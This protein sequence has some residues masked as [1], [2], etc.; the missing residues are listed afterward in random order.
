MM[1]LNR[2]IWLLALIAVVGCTSKQK[3][4]PAEQATL[5]GLKKSNFQSV[6]NGDSTN[7][8]VLT[9]ANGVEVTLTN[10]GGRI[11]SVMVPDREGNL[12]DVVLGFDN[13]D[14]YV[15]IDN[16]FGA[17]I[18]RYGN[19]IAN[20]KITVAGVEYQLPQNNF[21]HTL[22]GGPEG[23]HKK[24]FQVEQPDGQTVVFSYLSAD[25]EAGFPGN[26]DVK[27]TMTLTDDNAIDLQYEATTDKETVVNL[28]NHSYFNLNGDGNKTILDDSLTIHADAFTPVDNTFMTTGEISPVEGT[29]MDFR[30]PTVIGERIDNY[31]YVQLKNG[32]GYDHN[33]VLNTKGDV[34]QVAATVYSPETG[35]QL[36]VYTDEPGVQVYTGNFLDGT[37]TGKNGAL[38]AKRNA[39]CLETQKFPDSPN[40]ADWPSPYLKPGE[41]YTSRCIYKF[42]VKK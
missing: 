7:L 1:R 16:N 32:D 20:G 33:W 28:T 24:V 31:D 42:S 3:E 21:G 15:N 36:D 27:V 5:S 41:K 14:D 38:Y 26:L 25:G 12:K 29:P 6:V 39:I 10:Y 37:V 18:G 40:K 17:T 8:Y 34:N 2:M 23:F 22:H 19:R 13:I 35:I 11:V 4:T 30:T 9:N